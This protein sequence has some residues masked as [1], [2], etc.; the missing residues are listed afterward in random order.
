MHTPSR[1]DAGIILT[2]IRDAF[3]QVGNE[4]LLD[5]ECVLGVENFPVL[6]GVGTNGVV[7]NVART[8][9]PKS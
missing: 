7:V 5:R 4:N 2:C 9:G 8:G 3:E 1:A 6:I